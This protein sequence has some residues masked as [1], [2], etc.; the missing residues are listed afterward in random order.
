MV[1]RKSVELL[2]PAGTPEALKA[3]VVSGADAV[4]LGGKRFGARAYAGNFNLEELGEGLDF[5][6]MRGKRVYVTVNTLVDNGEFEQLADYLFFLYEAGVD[7]ILVQ[8]LG[9]AEFIRRHLSDLPVHGSTQM[10]VHNASGVRYLEEKGFRRVVLSR[11]TGLEEIREIKRLTSLE[12]EVFVHGALCFC[13]SGQCLF[14][15]LVGGRSGNRGSCAQPC[16]LA[17]ELVDGSGNNLGKDLP[18]KHLLSPKDLM[19]IRD[20]PRLIEAGVGALKIEGRMKRPEYVATVVRIYREA[21]DRALTDPD[22]Y[23]VTKEEVRDLAQIFNR[24]FTTGYLYGNQGRRLISYARPNNR[25][26]PLGRVLQVR[27][28]RVAFKTGLPLRTGDGI[29]FWTG[30]G[31]R[32]G[33]TVK[34]LYV[35]GLR[36]DEAEAGEQVEVILPFPVKEG[37]RIFKTHDSRLI[38]L[39]RESW[40]AD[41]GNRIPIK[42]KAQGRLGKPFRL[43]ADDGA[44]HQVEVQGQFLGEAAIKHSLDQEAVRAQ[45]ERL[46]N[47]PFKLE[48]FDCELDSGVMFPLSEINSLRRQMC[49][50]LKEQ[51]LQGCRRRAKGEPQGALVLYGNSIRKKARRLRDPDRAPR[52]TVSV[53]DFSGLQAALRGRADTV[54]FGGL[55]WRGRQPWSRELLQE[56]VDLCHRQQAEAFLILPRIWQEQDRQQV[57]GILEAALSLQADGVLVGDL[58]GLLLAQQSGLRV[59]TDYSVPVFNDGA[60]MVLMDEGVTGLT[61][62]PELNRDQ[63]R[64]LAY[65]GTPGL[66]LL[67]HGTLPLMVS[68]HC[69]LGAAVGGEALEGPCSAPCRGTQAFLKDR[70]GYLFPLAQDQSCRMTLYNARELCL[71]EYLGEILEMG[72]R[73]LR[74]ELRYQQSKQIETITTTYRRALNSWL[75]GRWNHTRGKDAWGVLS[76][77][78]SQGLTR[79]HYLRGVLLEEERGGSD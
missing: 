71:I 65:L 34:E 79:G 7:A 62:S 10:T 49:E 56:G 30:Q 2:A 22:G 75:A 29:E 48:K 17:Y 27:S 16:R 23:Q 33:M 69:V 53:L 41:S 19:L 70:M 68:E 20:L 3:A 13:Y 21:L 4:Y 52:L 59:I 54:Y 39:A 25:G 12:L 78:S 35:H 42:V 8:D 11:E 58:G 14:S 38:S 28:G 9:V 37:D 76:A 74:L 50:L 51:V 31:G 72:C 32:E 6:H 66:E 44:G 43:E 63:I 18:G 60:V 26:L 73:D 55:S 67:V 40:E 61:L 64:N 46:G 5:A 47:T 45:V 1:E 15:S 24:G 36:V 57:E 77:V